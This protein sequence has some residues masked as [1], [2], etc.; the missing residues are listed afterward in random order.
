MSTP[1]T[2]ST[3][4]LDIYGRP[5]NLRP[6]CLELRHKMMFVDPAQMSPGMVDDSS[7]TRVFLCLRT[8]SVLGPDDGQVSA[9]MCS[10]EGRPCFRG[11]ARPTAPVMP[12]INASSIGTNA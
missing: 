10:S 7:D 8:Q 3:P 11:S 6:C 2:P 1:H 9:K 12:T 5:L 4:T